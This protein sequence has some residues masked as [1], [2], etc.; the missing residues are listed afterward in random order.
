MIDKKHLLELFQTL[1][2]IDSPSYGERAVCDCINEYLVS[3][4]LQPL[5][6]DAAEKLGGNCG[7]LYCYVDGTPDLS[8]LLFSAH[9]DT[10][11]PSSGKR[12]MTH[13]D[14]TVTSAGDTVLGADDCAGIAAILEAL[15]VLLKGGPHRPLELVFSA[16]EEPYCAGIRQFDFSRLRSKE[17]YIFDLSGPVGG[18]AYQAPAILSFTAEFSGR[19]AHA[20]FAPEEGAHAILAAGRALASITCGRVGDATVNIGTISGGTADNIVPDRCV[21]TGE[22]RS[23]SDGEALQLLES[24][25]D[26]MHWSAESMNA[27]VE[28]RSTMNIPAYRT[29]LDLPVVR[30]FETACRD[31]D[32]PVNLVQTFGGSDN[33]C[34][35]RHGL[36]G[37]V[38]AAAMNNCHSCTEYTSES[39]L[40]R[41][42]ELAL[43]L[44]LSEE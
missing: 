21:L 41:A 15:A 12:M 1:V 7:N 31:L 33:N 39:E 29:D 44:M 6:D 18:A 16:A 11:E 30:R 43:R 8:P 34:F 17:A 28:V 9:M 26:A 22:I 36:S 42:A 37:I 4:G 10:V 20:G 23:F 25:T 5:E 19:S 2:S 3:L 13:E 38:V 40:V 24:V 14:G 27:T 32:I 35:T